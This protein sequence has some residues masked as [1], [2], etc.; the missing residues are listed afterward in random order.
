MS[1]YSPVILSDEH[2]RALI[3]A[4][5]LH[6]RLQGCP[7]DGLVGNAGCLRRPSYGA[8]GRRHLGLGVIIV[9]AAV[10]WDAPAFRC[11]S[12]QLFGE[13]RV[14]LFRDPLLLPQEFTSHLL[15]LVAAL[16]SRKGLAPSLF[17]VGLEAPISS[18]ISSVQLQGAI[19]EN[20][21]VPRQGLL[22]ASSKIVPTKL[23]PL[24]L[25]ADHQGTTSFPQRVQILRIGSLVL[26][27]MVGRS[28]DC[29]RRP[30]EGHPGG[31]GRVQRLESLE[32]IRELLLAPCAFA[33]AL[34][35][36]V[37]RLRGPHKGPQLGDLFWRWRRH[38]LGDV[39][40]EIRTVE[41]RAVR[42]L[43]GNGHIPPLH[44]RRQH[45]LNSNEDLPMRQVK[46]L[47][48]G[49]AKPAVLGVPPEVILRVDPTEWLWHLAVIVSSILIATQRHA[50]EEAKQP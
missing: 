7:E 11:G 39:L 8:R 6:E 41:Q 36:F 38:C 49:D 19:L 46:A 20:F 5:V 24:E 25:L 9:R 44:G 40:R 16:L 34:N 15:L 50:H 42:M 31:Q 29:S 17:D 30:A 47:S 3:G 2:L 33:A 37:E 14:E 35:D 1:L 10:T 43:G 32:S 4:R 12:R 22:P 45:A 23:P 26:R 48:T 27:P 28:R 18:S 13:L 21:S